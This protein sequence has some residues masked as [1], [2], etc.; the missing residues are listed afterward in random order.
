MEGVCKTCGS[1][2]STDET[3]TFCVAAES[4]HAGC[5]QYLITAGA[6]VNNVT[7]M[8]NSPLLSAANKGNV[9][10]VKL[11][12]GAGA[13]VN[14]ANIC[15]DTSLIRAVDNGHVECVRDLL[16]KGADVNIVNGSG[17]SAIFLATKEARNEC[18]ELLANYGA[19]VNFAKVSGYTI[20]ME[21]AQNGDY[22][23]VDFLIKA[24]ADVNKQSKNGQIAIVESALN[25]HEECTKLLIRAGA[26]V[27]SK[28]KGGELP[29][30]FMAR[31]GLVKGLDVMIKAGADVNVSQSDGSTA[32]MYA[33]VYRGVN[34]GIECVKLLL[35]AG[36]T[37]NKLNNK[38]YN[39]LFTHMRS[40]APYN[41]PNN[42][43][44]I[45][46]DKTMVLLLFAAGEEINIEAI[47]KLFN[48]VYDKSKV[49]S[50]L[51]HVIPSLPKLCL[52]NDCRQ[53]VR[54]HMLTAYPQDNLFI[55]IPRLP[56]PRPLVNY[57]L[58]DV[59][60]T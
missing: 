51:N 14:R 13:S 36:A 47:R 57:L 35:G 37:V 5:L 49:Q 25:G 9:N 10:C 44:H 54:K 39:A 8:G 42:V 59:S 26:D 2:Y 30:L 18:F 19:D 6:D 16:E 53:T 48:E 32:L 43:T 21:A 27:N 15:G 23:C 38:K 45:I 28:S 1:Y 52:M 22:K 29:L 41:F 31:Q 7:P 4:G 34:I 40:F 46:P 11:L 33:A 50:V 58:H 17:N 56:I 60:L 20:L 24:G 12:L 55:S 3:K